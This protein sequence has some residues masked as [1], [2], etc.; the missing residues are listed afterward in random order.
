MNPKIALFLSASLTT[1][2]LATLS[3]VVGKVISAPD[4]IAS[5][6]TVATAQQTTIA[7]LEQPTA[8]PTPMATVPSS[9]GPEE[10]ANIA[11]QAINRQDVYSVESSTYQGVEAFKVVFS[12]GDMVY[13]GLDRQVL[14]TTKLQPVVVNVPATKPPKKKD[15]NNDGGS[16]QASSAP[17]SG[18]SHEGGDSNESSGEHEGGD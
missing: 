5:A 18:D 15:N 13:I 7:L 14:T 11:A 6:P 3:G 16:V 12:S 10:A 2:V 8:L 9:L 4:V 17:S 1:F